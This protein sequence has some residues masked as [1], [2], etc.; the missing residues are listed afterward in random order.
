MRAPILSL[1][2]VVTNVNFIHLVNLSPF[3][4]QLIIARR[5]I[6]A[7]HAC[8]SAVYLDPMVLV[9]IVFCMTDTNNIG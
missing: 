9:V 1:C 7:R 3:V 4:A 2:I 5:G 8:N 6:V